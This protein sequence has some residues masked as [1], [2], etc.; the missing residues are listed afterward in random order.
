MGTRRRGS[1]PPA[2]A[3]YAA[4]PDED[5]DDDCCGGRRHRHRFRLDIVRADPADGRRQDAHDDA[6]R[7]KGH[8]VH[9]GAGMRHFHTKDGGVEEVLQWCGPKGNV[10][11]RPV[12]FD[13]RL[14]ADVNQIFDRTGGEGT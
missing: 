14:G 4:D 6:G 9:D 1:C 3:D 8:S 10:H 7:V 2:D 12:G 11:G 5:N 13:V